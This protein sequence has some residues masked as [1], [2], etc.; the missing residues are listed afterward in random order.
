MSRIDASVA[1]Q[2]ADANRPQQ[3]QREQ[4]DQAQ[5]ARR[6]ETQAQDPKA[7]QG[8]RPEEVRAAAERM[9][10]V[11]ES[12]TGRQLDFALNDRFKELVVRI[13]DRKSGEVIKE[14]PSKEFMKLRER[15][16]DLVGM[17]IDENA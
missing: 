17:F 13:S 7:L 12:A 10:R 2:I 14:F 16:N 8:A 5:E 4:A 11:I 6:L 3:A 15:L 9:Q 1:T